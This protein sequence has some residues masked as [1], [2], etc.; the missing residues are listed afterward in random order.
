MDISPNNEYTLPPIRPPV[1]MMILMKYVY[2]GVPDYVSLSPNDV[3]EWFSDRKGH[4]IGLAIVIELSPHIFLTECRPQCILP[5]DDL[6]GV[7]TLV[8]L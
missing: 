8:Y 7:C 2:T 4:V 3:G 6:L 1:G 5:C